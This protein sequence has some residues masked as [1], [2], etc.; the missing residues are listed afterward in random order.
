MKFEAT[1][2]GP[3]WD[4]MEGTGV[5]SKGVDLRKGQ[6]KLV[7]AVDPSVIPYGTKLKVWPNPF[8]D[9]NLVFT[10]ADTGG[11]FQGGVNKI[12]FFVASGRKDQNRWGRRGVSVKVVGR[13]SPKDVGVLGEPKMGAVKQSGRKVSGPLAGVDPNARAQVLQQYLAVRGRPG[14]LASLASGL[15]AAAPPSEASPGVPATKSASGGGRGPV[16]R[17]ARSQGLSPLKELFY[18]PLGGW[19]GTTPIGAIGGHSDHVHVAAGPKTTV[20]LGKRAKDFGLSVGE[21][22]HFGGKPT[23]GHAPNSYHY[24]DQAIDVSGAPA[25]MRAYA[26]YIARLYGVGK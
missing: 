5:T 16:G 11:A 8:G 2:Y 13:G 6:Q 26:H 9:R 24:R 1:A 23:G 19:K 12:D 14:A 10:A 21:N 15:E 7:V 22:S 25:Q 17:S 4:A 18:D 3:P 20:R